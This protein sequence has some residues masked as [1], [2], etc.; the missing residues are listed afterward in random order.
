MAYL[1]S[2]LILIWSVFS[3]P[4]MMPP[5][6][7]L[8]EYFRKHGA[9]KKTYRQIPNIRHTKSR[10][11]TDSR[12]VL[13]LAFP[14][15]LKPGYV[16]N[17]DVVGAAQTGDAPTTSEWSTILLSTKVCLML[18]VQSSRMDFTLRLPIGRR[19]H[20][21]I[22]ILTNPTSDIWNLRLTWQTCW[23]DFVKT[24]G[25]TVVFL[26]VYNFQ[27]FWSVY[28]NIPDVRDLNVR[29]SYHLMRHT[30]RPLW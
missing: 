7:H 22:I 27:S 12:L 18:E 19:K 15:P 5:E 8:I 25:L 20:Q 26:F 10:N 11:L 30:R 24:G 2:S 21:M 1:K 14:N 9:N 28:N 23:R 29:Y 13:Q 17:E 3:K 4:C 6:W 16:E